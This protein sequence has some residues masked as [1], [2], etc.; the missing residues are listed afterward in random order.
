MH[1]MGKEDYKTYLLYNAKNEYIV[2]LM[3]LLLQKYDN[4]ITI[5][6]CDDVLKSVFYSDGSVAHEI[7]EFG[8][9]FVQA[10]RTS[11]GLG[12]CIIDNEICD[13]PDSEKPW[14]CVKTTIRIPI[15][16]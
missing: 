2:I 15:T 6:N 13:S 14:L 12:A 5:F 10:L 3:K 8:L 11:K 1:F 7:D 9:L 4:K 16:R